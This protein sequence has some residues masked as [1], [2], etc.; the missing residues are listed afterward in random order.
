MTSSDAETLAIR[1]FSQ[2]MDDPRLLSAFLAQSGEEPA[3]LSD[4]LTE[5]GFQIGVLD[6][7]LAEDA[8]LTAFCEA[9]NVT[10]HDIALARHVLDPIA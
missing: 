8:R 7:L 1:A 5:R 6:F 4:R 3:R 9:V 2:V 10:P